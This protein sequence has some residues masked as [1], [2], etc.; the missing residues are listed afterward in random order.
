MRALEGPLPR[1]RPGLFHDTPLAALATL[2]ATWA[3]AVVSL[4]APAS[5]VV[6]L[7][8]AHGALLGTALAW[9]A[10]GARRDRWAPL[11]AS[12]ALGAA[13]AGA[14]LHPLGALAYVTVPTWLVWRRAAC[15]GSRAWRPMAGIAAGA[16]FGL[17]LG[18][19]LLVNTSLTFGYR[20]R[21][22]PLVELADWWA[23]DLGANVLTAE[24]FFRGALFER[25]YRRWSFAPA[26]AVSTAAA[27]IRY[28]ADPLLPHSLGIAAGAIFYMAL[29]GVGNCWL[30]ARTGS[31]G[32]ALAAASVFFGA[33]RLLAPR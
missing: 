18:G 10:V 32:P 5:R 14:A 7:A 29:L 26:A 27:V 22:G 12:L 21:T 8:V 4:P 28:L 15:L 16:L 23:Y 6:G 19:H 24:L 33:Y 13:A 20:V 2:A 3:L 17:L 25:L 31:L 1:E 9:T 30:L 11:Q